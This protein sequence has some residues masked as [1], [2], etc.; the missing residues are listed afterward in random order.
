MLVF[1][2]CMPMFQHSF[3]F[4]ALTLLI[5]VKSTDPPPLTS[6][7]KP[8]ANLLF[9]QPN[10]HPAKQPFLPYC[11]RNYLSLREIQLSSHLP[12]LP[13]A[14]IP[15]LL[16]GKSSFSPTDRPPLA[17]CRLYLLFV[18]PTFP[19]T[20]QLSLTYCWHTYP[21]FVNSPFISQTTFLNL[22]LTYLPLILIILYY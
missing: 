20:K 18:L 2:S 3:S 14:D 5:L 13:W 4:I 10:F 19:P 1:R 12:S 21:F 8:D 17:C 15:T 22:L 6:L 11:L 7:P 16:F 9:V